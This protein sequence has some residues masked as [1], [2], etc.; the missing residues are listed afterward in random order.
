MQKRVFLRGGLANESVDGEM[1]TT[2]CVI[3]T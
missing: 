3:I 1:V 2:T